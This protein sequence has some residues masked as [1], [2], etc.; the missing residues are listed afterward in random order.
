MATRSV[1]TQLASYFKLKATM[2]P[3]TVEKYEHMS[4]VPYASVVGCLI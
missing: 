3:T 1:S 4:H 2:F